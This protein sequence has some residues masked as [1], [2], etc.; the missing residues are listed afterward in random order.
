M[1]YSS[2]HWLKPNKN[3]NED[4]NY[5][6]PHSSIGYMMPN[7]FASELSMDKMTA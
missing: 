6:R 3:W 4:Y 7:E 5:Q 1:K 2:H